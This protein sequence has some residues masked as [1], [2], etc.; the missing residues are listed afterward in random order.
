MSASALTERGPEL[1]L[2]EASPAYT[3]GMTK[4]TRSLK[5]VRNYVK[6]DCLDERFFKPQY[7]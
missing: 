2:N 3:A 5:N 6:N 4:T 7:V 1:T